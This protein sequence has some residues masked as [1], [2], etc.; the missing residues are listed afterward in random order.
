[1]GWVATSPLPPWGSPPLQSGGQN[2]RWPTSGLGGY[3]T[4]AALKVPTASKQGA[5]SVVAH[6]W[7]GWLHKPCRLAGTTTSEQ[8][9]ESA[10]AAVKSG[11]TYFFG[12]LFT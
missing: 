9:A 8:G 3:I 2:Q 1:M 10:V 5:K 12:K 7:A 4:P 11:K 6:K